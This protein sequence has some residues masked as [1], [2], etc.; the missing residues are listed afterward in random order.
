[1]P[2]VTPVAAEL[3]GMEKSLLDVFL[4]DKSRLFP[5]PPLTLLSHEGSERTEEG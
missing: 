1:M 5:F 2:N 4:L 3:R